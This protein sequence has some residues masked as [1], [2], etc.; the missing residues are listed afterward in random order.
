MPLFVSKHRKALP[1]DKDA[2]FIVA[3]AG[4]EVHQEFQAEAHE[5]F[6]MRAAPRACAGDEVIYKVAVGVGQGDADAAGE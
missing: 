4:E 3:V 5:D 1:S 6:D 2:A